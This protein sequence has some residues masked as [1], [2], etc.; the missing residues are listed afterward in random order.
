V[1]PVILTTSVELASSAKDVW[2]LVTDT[3]RA[4]RLIGGRPVKYRAIEDGEKTSARFVGETE[5]GGF[6]M[7][8]EEAPFEWTHEKSF[9][10]FRRMRGGPLRSYIYGITLD[11]LEGGGTRVNVT[12]TLEPRHWLLK[13]IV[14]F[15]AKSF[16]N[17]AAAVIR[18]IDEHVHKN[19]PSPFERPRSPAN[20]HALERGARELEKRGID[21]PAIEKLVELLR[22]GA[23]ADLIRVRPFEIAESWKLDRNEVLRAFLHSVTTGLFELRWALVCPS[24]RT[25][26]V[27][28]ES[29]DA[30]GDAGHCQLCDINYGVELDQAVEATFVAHPA[31][32]EVTSQMFCMGGPA[33]TPHVLVQKNVDAGKTVSL[34]APQGEGA[35]YRLFSRGGAMCTLEVAADA[36]SEVDVEIASEEAFS[37]ASTRV[38]PGGAVRVKNATKDDRHVKIERMTWANQAATAHVVTLMSE[39]RRLF[40]RDLLK[41]STPLKVASSAILF[42]DLTGSTALYTTV[43]DAAAF[44]LVDDHFDVLRASLDPHGG[45][46]VK[47]MGDAIMA[48][49]PD[50]IAAIRAATECLRAF[51]A[52]KKKVPH[53]DLIGLKLGVFSGPCYVVTANGAIDYFGQTVNCAARVQH[54]ATSGELILEQSLFE[55]LPAADREKLSR[56]EDLTTTVKGVDKPLELVRT[57]LSAD[58]QTARASSPPAP[59]EHA[60]KTTKLEQESSPS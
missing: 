5:A 9:S 44:R 27:E 18:K 37:T 45:T 42:S 20:E 28:V 13:P 14:G 23:D 50:P 54:L 58:A 53:G 35:R 15:Q 16:V 39:F 34:E 31:V 19:T 56:I 57:K 12:L 7:T 11:P 48:A 29:L 38:A 8:Y 6:N 46:V 36:P 59:A 33:R 1:E 10:V 3:D 55:V 49:F 60:N 32:R 30:I 2:P 47:T 22:D 51:D 17:G 43:G 25:A 52:F 41:P 24:C 26:N 40:S 21:L 4:N